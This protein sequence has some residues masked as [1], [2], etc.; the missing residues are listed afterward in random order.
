[1]EE[2]RTKMLEEL[3]CL[4]ER[5]TLEQLRVILKISRELVR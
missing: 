5:A 2:V 4:I 1:M 3:K